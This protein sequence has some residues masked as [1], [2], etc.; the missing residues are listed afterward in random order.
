[1]EKI[2][3]IVY[4]ICLLFNI[5]KLWTILYSDVRD[6]GRLNYESA[7]MRN[8]VLVIILTIIAPAGTVAYIWID[9]SERRSGY[10]E[11]F[12][13]LRSFRRAKIEFKINELWNRGFKVIQ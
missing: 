9:L 6:V 11:P 5:L 8:I 3:I 10:K 1:M 2:F 7:E 13:K 12:L 4:S